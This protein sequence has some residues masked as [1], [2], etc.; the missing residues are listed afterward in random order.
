MGSFG[1]GR[2]ILKRHAALPHLHPYPSRSQ[3]PSTP[4]YPLCLLP[5]LPV[6]A[7]WRPTVATVEVSRCAPEQVWFHTQALRQG[8]VLYIHGNPVKVWVLTSLAGN[9]VSSLVLSVGEP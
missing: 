7:A 2:G 3:D 1:D 4:Q 6:P 9:A 5:L 8:C